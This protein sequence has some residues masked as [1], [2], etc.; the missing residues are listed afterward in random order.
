MILMK[1]WLTY[2]QRKSTLFVRVI[3]TVSA[4]HEDGHFEHEHHRADDDADDDHVDDD[5]DAGR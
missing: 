3:V 2:F 5:D 4:I 1:V